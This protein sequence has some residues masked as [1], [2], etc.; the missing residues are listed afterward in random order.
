[1]VFKSVIFD[2]AKK[3]EVNRHPE[4]CGCL[5]PDEILSLME[6]GTVTIDKFHEVD[7]ERAKADKAKGICNPTWFYFY[8]NEKFIE[9]QRGVKR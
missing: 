3:C 7:V 4:W 9:L 2:I 1:M 8:P 5:R 6:S